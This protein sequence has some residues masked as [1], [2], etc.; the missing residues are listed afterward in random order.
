MRVLTQSG[1]ARGL[2]VVLTVA[3][4]LGSA[5]LVGA[6][7][8]EA[9]GAA[10][11]GGAGSEG[12]SW[13]IAADAGV[14]TSS[15]FGAGWQDALSE[16]QNDDPIV[17]DSQTSSRLYPGI[18]LALLVET[19]MTRAAPTSPGGRFFPDA[20]R[21]AT[22]LSGQRLG[23]RYRYTE[24]DTTGT[25]TIARD[26]LTVPVEVGLRGRVFDGEIGYH[27]ALGPA[28]MI[29]VGGVLVR[30]EINDSTD[31]TIYQADA[32][33]AVVPAGTVRVG[34]DYPL[35]PGRLGIS[36]R[37]A[38]TILDIESESKV[39][40]YALSPRV[41]YAVST[42]ELARSIGGLFE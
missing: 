8:T 19:D 18:A 3:W 36:T 9:E 22:G 42:A 5:L 29:P 24:S 15:Y 32:F 28:L 21:M 17:P 23:G 14:A 6:Q 25:Q 27:A 10:G 20:L 40:M 26:Y 30:T 37:G 41:S 12:R 39:W 38:V 33:R 7:G 35:G 31:E 13:S 4:M 11:S 34:L 16:R 1:A 2:A